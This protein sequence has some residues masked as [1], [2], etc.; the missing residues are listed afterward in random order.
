MVMAGDFKCRVPRK[1]GNTF[2]LVGKK[3]GAMA[4]P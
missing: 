2:K 1:K 4:Q 3:T